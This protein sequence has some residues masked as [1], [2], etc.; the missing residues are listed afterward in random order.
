MIRNVLKTTLVQSTFGK[1]SLSAA[2]LIACA[3]AQPAFAAPAKSP[4]KAPAKSSASLAPRSANWNAQVVAMPDG[5]YRVGNP[6][7]KVKLNE[8]VSYTCPHCAE[9]HKQSD[10]VLRLT[11]VPRGQL[12]I[13]V[14]NLLRNPIDATVAMLTNCGNPKRFFVRHGAFFATQDKW[15]APLASLSESQRQRWVQGS[16][17][18]RFRAIASD[19]GFYDMMERWGIDRAQTDACLADTAVLDKL[20]QQQAEVAKLGF[21][22]TPSFTLNGEKLDGHDWASVSKEITAR[23][24]K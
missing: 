19:L 21:D 13:T 23:L 24:G 17:T 16:M 4:A 7:A 9:F 3:T 14:T 10:P 2:V 11:S 8:F 1:A 12:S 5:S 20:K 18:D 6:D 22:S 15:M